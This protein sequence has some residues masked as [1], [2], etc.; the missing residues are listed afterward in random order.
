M[1]LSRSRTKDRILLDAS[2]SNTHPVGSLARPPILMDFSSRK[3][4]VRVPSILS[5]APRFIVVEAPGP[6][7]A[8]AYDYETSN[9]RMI[10][11]WM[12]PISKII[13]AATLIDH[14]ATRRDARMSHNGRGGVGAH[15]LL[16]KGEAEE[17]A[18]KYQYLGSSH[19]VAVL[20]LP[21]VLYE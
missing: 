3:L 4:S 8:P 16:A 5:L 15:S 11:P 17:P 19:F 12:S 20:R 6:T 9:V 1:S 2:P 21:P 7:D 10:T 14:G 18:L 13:S